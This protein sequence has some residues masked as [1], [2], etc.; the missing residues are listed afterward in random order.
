[1]KNI[2]GLSLLVSLMALSSLNFLS[3]D[4]NVVQASATTKML[5]HNSVLYNKEGKNTGTTYASYSKVEVDD[6]LI[7][8]GKEKYYKITDKN[9][10]IKVSNI[11]GLRRKVIHNSYVYATSQ[12]RANNKLV[13]AGSFVT[14]YGKS[15][16]FKNNQKYYRIGGPK[17]QYI[18]VKNVGSSLGYGHSTSDNLDVR[19]TVK[20]LKSG[21][22]VIRDNH[23]RVINK[24]V[25]PGTKLVIDRWEKTKFANPGQAPNDYYRIKGTDNWINA[26]DVEVIGKSLR[27][28]I[29]LSSWN[30]YDSLHYTGVGMDKDID[31]YNA[32]GTI[33]DH[34]GQKIRKQGGG[35]KV[36]ALL[37]IWL[38]NKN[39]AELFYKLAGKNA[40]ATPP[41]N[42]TGNGYYP[43]GIEFTNGVGY[44]KTSDVISNK[45][46]QIKLAPSNTPE[47]AKAAYEASLTK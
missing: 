13:K 47:Q 12:R 30:D 9:Q 18:K 15:Y 10:Y 42:Y 29:P 40:Y 24:N 32:D 46:A 36:S 41:T 44:V 31:V 14:T 8:I 45:D 39:K 37:Y 7:T 5:M 17:K 38:P 23:G 1:M 4:T 6:K 25:K 43:G 2:K 33:Q 26:D 16:K 28:A 35:L 3:K 22:V 20:K 34:N 11:N 27:T 19:V 21:W